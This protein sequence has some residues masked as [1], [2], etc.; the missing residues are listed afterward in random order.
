[1]KFKLFAFYALSLVS[2]TL[3][4]QEKF[5]KKGK[6]SL[7]WGY[8][9]EAYTKSDIHLVGPGYDYTLYN[10]KAHD[11]PENLSYTYIDITQFTVPQFD[12]RL[13]YYFNDH[14]AISA[15]WDH[16]KYVLQNGQKARITG[17][18]TRDALNDGTLDY[19]PESAAYVGEYVNEEVT[20][21]ENFIK[22]E[23][24]DGL[25]FARVSIERIDQ[26][27]A[28]KWFSVT[29]SNEFGTG[30]VLPWTDFTHLG[31][32]RHTNRLHMSGW[33]VGIYSG[34][35][36]EYKG[37]FYLTSN[38]GGGFINLHDVE[39]KQGFDDW[40]KQ[41]FWFAKWNFGLGV[42][43]TAFKPKND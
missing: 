40:A 27:Y 31:G 5:S 33:G 38:V 28:S 41:R 35:R 8:S 30:P 22:Y 7:F 1:M 24:T 16:M 10:V 39:T 21:R 3:L 23:H 12:F 18:I 43:L 29:L 37:T 20:L 34:L 13:A 26:I 6:F 2:T 15:G 11:K 42:Y 17:T 36:A 14:W 4:A 19:H 9:R 25:N 32:E